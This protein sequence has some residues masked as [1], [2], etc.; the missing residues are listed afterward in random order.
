MTDNLEQLRYPIGRY[1]K[2][3]SYTKADLQEWISVIEALPGWMD[4]CIENLDEHQLQTPYR[5]D[6]WT[7]IQVVHHVADSHMNAYIRLKLGLTENNPTI[8]PYAEA[9]WAKL[10]DVSAVPVNVSNTLLHA[11]HRRWVVVL[12]NMKDSDWECT[13]YHPEK[14]RTITLWE[15]T[16]LYAWHSRHHTEHIRQLR[17]RMNW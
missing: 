1:Q 11:L 14:E 4:L 2:P 12:K 6:G 7:I 16:A 5:P 17:Q 15:L 13:V 3:D 9:E 8:K 10:P